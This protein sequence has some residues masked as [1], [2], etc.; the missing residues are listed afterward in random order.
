MTPLQGGHKTMAQLTSGHG[1]KIHKINT[2]L[3]LLLEAGG[4]AGGQEGSL[5]LASRLS[6]LLL[7]LCK[8]EVFLLSRANRSARLRLSTR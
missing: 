1:K 6:F 8:V 7:E 5:D 3:P 2:L 4:R